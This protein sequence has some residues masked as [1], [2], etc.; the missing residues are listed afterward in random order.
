MGDVIS[1]FFNSLPD[2]QEETD[3]TFP[4]LEETVSKIVEGIKAQ[5]EAIDSPAHYGG[6]GNVYEAINVIEAYNMD[7]VEG[8]VLKYL[9]RYK[10]KNGLEC[11]KKAQWYLNRLIEQQ[12][13]LNGK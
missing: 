9:L 13:N 7:F 5:K 10:K 4:G 1:A 12:E 2:K 8:N 11:L 6:K 3:I